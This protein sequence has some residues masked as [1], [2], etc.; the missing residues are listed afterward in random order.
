MS[1]SFPCCNEAENGLH[2]SGSAL[3]LENG[4]LTCILLPGDVP[5]DKAFGTQMRLLIGQLPAEVLLG[6]DT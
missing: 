1:L 6:G 3:C 2:D 5:H 4:G